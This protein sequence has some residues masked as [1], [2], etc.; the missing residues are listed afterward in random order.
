MGPCG[1]AAGARDVMKA[2]LTEVENAV[3]HDVVVISSGCAGRCSLEPMITVE[4]RDEPELQ[5]GNLNGKKIVE[6]FRRHV[7]GGRVVKKYLVGK[8]VQRTS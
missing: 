3:V 1:I 7:V 2:L 8:D 6:I 4:V 5:Y